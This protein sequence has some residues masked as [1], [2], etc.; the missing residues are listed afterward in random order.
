MSLETRKIYADPTCEKCEGRGMYLHPNGGAAHCDCHHV[1]KKR[2][3]MRRADFPSKHIGS[4]VAGYTP[5]N[6]SE[7]QV[8]RIVSAWVPGFKSGCRGLYL[9]GPAGTGKTHLLV[10]IGKAIIDRHYAEVSYYSAAA[11]LAGARQSFGEQHTENPFDTAAQA[12]VLLLDDIGAEKPSEWALSEFYRL[13]NRR[14]NDGLTTLV[15]SNVNLDA[16][17]GLYDARIAD[18]LHEMCAQVWCN[19]PSRRRESVNAE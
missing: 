14:Y 7:T 6:D 3:L 11:L 9:Y 4:T 5:Q 17:E 12:R 15:T 19:G 10:A 18:R 13:F 2:V 16:F 8:K 1:E